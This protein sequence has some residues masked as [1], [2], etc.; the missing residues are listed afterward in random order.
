MEKH[1]YGRC[2]GARRFGFVQPETIRTGGAVV[3]GNMR[4]CV[5]GTAGSFGG[6]TGEGSSLRS[7]KDSFKDN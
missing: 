2:F 1:H 6:L 5:I 3:N 4:V 7:G